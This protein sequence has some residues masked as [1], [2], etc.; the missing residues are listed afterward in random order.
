MFSL[1]EERDSQNRFEISAVSLTPLKFSKK[2]CGWH[3]YEIFHFIITKIS[4]VYTAEIVLAVSNTLEMAMTIKSKVSA[5]SLTPG[6]GFQPCYSH[7]WY[8]II[9]D[10]LGEYEA[11]CETVLTS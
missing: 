1:K 2:N 8:S 3:P 7:R 4:A 6:N 10:Y 5:V 11:I 9:I